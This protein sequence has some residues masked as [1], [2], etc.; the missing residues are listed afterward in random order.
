[1]KK[2]GKSAQATIFIILAILILIIVI[3]IFIKTSSQKQDIG[4]KYFEQK[5]LQPSINN[6]QNFIVDCLEETSK[7]AITTI[8]IQGGYFNKPD[9]YFDMEWA[10]I[11]YYYYQ[12]LIIMPEKTKIE[13]ELSSYINSN[14]ESCID[15]IKF[16]N[17]QLTYSK[18]NTKTSINKGYTS[19]ATQL[20]VKIEHGGNTIDFNLD[21]H[22]TTINSSLYEIIEVADYITNSHKENPE[23]MCINCIAELAK[24]KQLYVDFIAIEKDTALVMIL[25]NRT[26]EEPYIFQ[27]MNKYNFQ[28]NP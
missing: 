1:M 28:V 22:I 7:Q 19:F 16:Q 8:G 12:G 4:R 24:E 6:I 10:F 17:F 21:Q 20:P 18:P 26:M 9:Y 13:N 11:P 23:L 25:E 3:V 5:G 27:F 14:I 2:R 15:E